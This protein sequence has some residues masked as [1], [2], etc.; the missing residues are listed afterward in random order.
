[1]KLFI[2]G[3]AGFI[4]SNFIIQQINETSNEILNFDKLT[5]AGNPENL[6]G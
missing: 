5:Y 6:T 2:T 1:M 3:G 4:G